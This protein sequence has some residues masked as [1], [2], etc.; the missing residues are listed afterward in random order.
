MIKEKR[1]LICFLKNGWVVELEKRG[2]VFLNRGIS[3]YGVVK[4]L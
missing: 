1:R 4:G 3:V 2:E